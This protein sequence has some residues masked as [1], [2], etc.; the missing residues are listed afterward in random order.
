MPA[1]AEPQAQPQVLTLPR[2]HLQLKNILLLVDLDRHSHVTLSY[3]LR[4]QKLREARIIA[5]HLLPPAEGSFVPEDPTR[6]F[7]DL[8]RRHSALELQDFELHTR[9]KEVAHT[10]LL[11][12]GTFDEVIP[13]LVEAYDIDLVAI[14]CHQHSAAAKF[15]FGSAAEEIFRG[16]DVPVLNIGPRL[17]TITEQKPFKKILLATHFDDASLHAANYALSFAM[18]GGGTVTL[19]HVIE[20]SRQL[21]EH[22]QEKLA[23]IRD[24]LKQLVPKD[25][26]LYC[27]PEILVEYGPP[28][29]RILEAAQREE[30]DLIV[31]GVRKPRF[32]SL[33]S[34]AMHD[35]AFDVLSQANCPVLTLNH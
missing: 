12:N 35:V 32:L 21:I 9:L 1:I 27:S 4:L 20:D 25:A 5:C 16:T 11:E 7:P 29:Q 34:H 19:L 28:A 3:A 22:P 14:G 17:T 15:F 26:D 10:L 2:S 33:A 13:R 23:D 18:D 6:R 31:L 24:H 30:A 8:E